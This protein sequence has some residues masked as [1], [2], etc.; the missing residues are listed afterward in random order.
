MPTLH[1]LG[2]GAALSSG[3]R[4]TT[5]LAVAAPG[6]V[7]LIDCGGDAAQRMLA[8]G[9]ALDEL[10]GVVLTHEHPDHI[11][12]FPLLVERLWLAGRRHPLPVHGPEGTLERARR[13]WTTFDTSGWEGVPEL[14]WRGVTLEQDA[15][16]LE[17]AVWT[18]TA[19]PGEHSVPSIALRVEHRET[20]SVVAYSA[21]TRPTP[22]VA[23]LAAGAD[24]L[25]HEATGGEAGGHS[26]AEAAAEIAAE[27]GVGRLVLVHLPPEAPDLEEARRRFAPI[28]LGEDGGR[29]DF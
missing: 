27:A 16:V 25:I 4:T 17:S 7:L 15:N 6:S 13:L 2:T 26:T 22:A 19:A 10:V 20:G 12:G 3:A 9:I 8:Q 5:M 29:Y 28:E 11:G 1:L 21:D 14:E 24:L 18:V 23:R